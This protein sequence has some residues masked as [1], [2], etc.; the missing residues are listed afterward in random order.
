MIDPAA[1]LADVPEA[2]RK[3]LIDEYIGLCRA[4]TESRWKLTELD[5]G[6]FC[7]A[8]YCIV[9]GKLSGSYPSGPTKPANF[10]TACRTLENAPPTPVGDRSLRIL[11][12]RLLPAIYEV[13]NNRGVGHVGGDVDANSMDALLVRQ[14][15]AWVLAELV[16]IFHSTTIDI[17]QKA[18][19]AISQRT[20]PLVWEIDGMRRVLDPD[21]KAQ[22][23]ALALLY[24]VNDWI[25][26]KT[27]NEWV[28]YPSKFKQSVLRP[29]FEKRLVEMKTDRVVITPRGIQHVEDFLLKTATAP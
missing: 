9:S 14:S 10:V 19:D 1:L 2:L 28:I 25:G 22:D 23:R 4:F 18:V 6:R 13:R 11:I 24:S 3:A 20:H 15:C 8:A 5:A 17:A 21:M 26:V 12:P 29:L 16:R 7:E 27:L